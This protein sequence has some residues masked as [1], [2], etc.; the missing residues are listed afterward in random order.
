MKRKLRAVS[1]NRDV[2]D[3]AVE[4]AVS[5]LTVLDREPR[6]VEPDFDWH[7]LRVEQSEAMTPKGIVIPDNLRVNECVIVKSGPGRRAENGEIYPMQFKPGDRIITDPHAKPMLMAVVDGEQIFGVRD[8][9]I[10][11]RVLPRKTSLVALS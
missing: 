11:M 8:C 3:K 6:E 7:L 1:S 9:Q 2:K 10:A 5:R 4:E